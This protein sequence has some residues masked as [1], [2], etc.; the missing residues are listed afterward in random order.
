MGVVQFGGKFRAGDQVAAH[1]GKGRPHSA[2]LRGLQ[3]A[4]SD[5]A[6]EVPVLSQRRLALL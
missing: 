1:L 4:A 2:S 6:D 3:C 5:L